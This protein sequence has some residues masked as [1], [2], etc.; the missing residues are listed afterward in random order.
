MLH[1]VLFFAALISGVSTGIALLLPDHERRLE[2][3]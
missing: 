2:A 3:T 1:A